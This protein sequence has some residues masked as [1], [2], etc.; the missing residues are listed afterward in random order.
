MLPHNK[1]C[2]ILRTMQ[3]ALHSPTSYLFVENFPISLAL[4]CGADP[5]KYS[6]P[7]PG[8]RDIIDIDI[9]IDTITY[10]YT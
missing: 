2:L 8:L 3:L 1:K 7:P 10:T 6:S 9:D 5:S 4:R